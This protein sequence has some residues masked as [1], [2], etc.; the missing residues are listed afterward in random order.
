MEPVLKINARDVGTVYLF[1]PERIASIADG[2][3]GITAVRHG[4]GY[5]Y[6]EGVSARGLKREIQKNADHPIAY[7]KVEGRH[8]KTYINA[9]Y[10]NSVVPHTFSATVE[11]KKVKVNGSYIRYGDHGDAA[12]TTAHQ[13]PFEVAQQVRRALMRLDQDEDITEA[14]PVEEEEE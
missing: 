1:Q 4:N 2:L 11:E 5:F 6:A 14:E 13:S 10:V 8:G 3:N 7:V 12:G 9:R